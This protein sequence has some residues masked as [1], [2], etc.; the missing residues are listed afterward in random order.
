VVGFHHGA[1]EFAL[2]CGLDCLLL[3]WWMAGGSFFK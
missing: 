3:L 2:V 1:D